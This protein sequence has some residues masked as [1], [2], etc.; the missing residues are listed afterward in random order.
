MLLLHEAAGY[1]EAV[2]AAKGLVGAA[3][4]SQ[5]LVQIHWKSPELKQKDFFRMKEV[6]LC[7]WIRLSRLEGYLARVRLALRVPA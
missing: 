1:D 2:A 5:N 7:Y 4:E 6:E 3:G